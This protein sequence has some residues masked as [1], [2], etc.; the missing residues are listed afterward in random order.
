[1]V[2]MAFCDLSYTYHIQ[3]TNVS[4]ACFRHPTVGNFDVSPNRIEATLK[5]KL[6]SCP[7]G[8]RNYGYSGGCNFFFFFFLVREK[9]NFF[10]KK[11]NRKLNKKFPIFSKGGLKAF[12]LLQ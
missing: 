5:K 6:V 2:Q 7:A 1:M 3:V 12:S 4:P 11:K 9:Q 8:G 10:G